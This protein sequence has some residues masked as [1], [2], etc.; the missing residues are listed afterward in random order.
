MEA[1]LYELIRDYQEGTALKQTATPSATFAFINF[2][3]C[4]RPSGASP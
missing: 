1:R 3:S 4:T 2:S